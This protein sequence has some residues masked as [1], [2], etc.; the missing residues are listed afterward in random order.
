VG[1]AIGLNKRDGD[2]A[3]AKREHVLAGSDERLMT[4]NIM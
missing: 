4:K 1:R 3:M 2:V